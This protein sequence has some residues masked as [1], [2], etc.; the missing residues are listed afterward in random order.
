MR[1]T[2]SL[3][4]KWPQ[5]HTLLFE[6]QGAADVRVVCPQDVKT[7]S[8]ASRVERRS[9]AGADP[10]YAAKEDQRSMDRQEAP[11]R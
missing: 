6:E 1:E 3:R 9:V 8:D 10:S 11:Q 2:R 7:A 4:I 5:R